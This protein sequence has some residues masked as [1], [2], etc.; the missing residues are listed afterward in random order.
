MTT[1]NSS[2]ELGRTDEVHDHEKKLF[3]IHCIADD[4][5]RND[6]LGDAALL[7]TL[8]L[9]LLA[10]LRIEDGWISCQDAWQS[11]LS[12]ELLD[13]DLVSTDEARREAAIQVRET[14]DDYFHLRVML[15]YAAPKPLILVHT[16]RAIH[17]RV[18]AKLDD[19]ERDTQR[20]QPAIAAH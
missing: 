3:C 15:R 6:A 11:I 2:Q 19:F 13:A 18:V 20:N 5:E 10:Q 7:A 12:A 17:K 9:K 16:E 4:A 1:T 8:E 14:L